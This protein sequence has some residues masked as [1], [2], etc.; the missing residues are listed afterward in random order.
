MKF[1]AARRYAKEYNRISAEVR[2]ALQ[3]F[4]DQG[5]EITEDDFMLAAVRGQAMAA[6]G[7]EDPMWPLIGL[8][9][10]GRSVILLEGNSGSGTDI[11]GLPGVPGKCG[12]PGR[13]Q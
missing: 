1:L 2:T 5:G 13:W 11:Q 10:V 4:Q 6:P 3:R 8:V 9:A 12:G 7:S